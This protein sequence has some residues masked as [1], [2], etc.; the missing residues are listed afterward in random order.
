MSSRAPRPGLP[1]HLEHLSPVLAA[2]RLARS[3]AYA[4]YSGYRVG[5]A[6]LTKSGGVYAGCNVEN[7][8]YGAT[9]CAERSAVSAMIAA[10]D[11][12]PV[13]AIVLTGGPKPAPPCG[14]CR[15]VLAEFC[16]ELHLLLIAED[17]ASEIVAR[18]WARLSV[19]LPHA[20]RLASSAKPRASGRTR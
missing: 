1:K 16:R 17:D 14:I 2:A 10:G 8:T 4:P 7:A 12:N 5:A 20:F 13:S 18:S 6:I 15:Q 3:R 11:S 9:L 19:L